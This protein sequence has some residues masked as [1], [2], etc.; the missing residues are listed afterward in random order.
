M[1]S[2][3]P[4]ASSMLALAFVACWALRRYILSPAAVMRHLEVGP[5]CWP[6]A[7][8]FAGELAAVNLLKSVPAQL[9]GIHSQL[10]HLRRRAFLLCAAMQHL[11]V[12]CCC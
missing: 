4:S 12:G 6:T 8:L 2:L 11:E 7:F 3:L 9:S 10:L 1:R 5:G